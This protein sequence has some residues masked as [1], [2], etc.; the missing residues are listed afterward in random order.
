MEINRGTAQ[1]K[2]YVGMLDDQSALILLNF[3]PEQV[4]ELLFLFLSLSALL[5]FEGIEG[6]PMCALFFP[7]EFEGKIH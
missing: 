4:L 2:P 5:L 3:G 7:L 6:I 1:F